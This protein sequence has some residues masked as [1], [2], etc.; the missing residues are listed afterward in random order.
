LPCFSLIF[1]LKFLPVYFYK[2]I[3]IFFENSVLCFNALSSSIQTFRNYSYF[4][5]CFVEIATKEM[6]KLVE[7]WKQKAYKGTF[8]IP[9]I[10]L[11]KPK[12]DI[13]TRSIDT[14][15]VK[16]LY[17]S[18]KDYGSVNEDIMVWC[19]IE[20]DLG[21]NPTDEDVESIKA[22]FEVIAGAHSMEA[23][24]LLAN[25]YPRN[26]LYTRPKI[27]LYVDIDSLQSRAAARAT[28]GLD[29]IIRG[30]YREVSKAE[31]VLQIHRLL[32]HELKD[33]QQS[34][35]PAAIRQ[36][37]KNAL[38]YYALNRNTLGTIMVLAGKHGELWEL[39]ERCLTGR[40]MP[41]SWKI[42]KTINK[43][44]QMGSL[45]P[46][47]LI[48]WMRQVCSG[49]ITLAD[50]QGKCLAEKARRKVRNWIRE[51][52]AVKCQRVGDQEIEEMEWEELCA[53]FPHS[54]QESF[55]DT[56]VG[57]AQARSGASGPPDTMKETL[58]SWIKID[59][60]SQEPVCTSIQNFHTFIFTS[61][62]IFFLNVMILLSCRFHCHKVRLILSGFA[63]DL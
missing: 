40:D 5:L 57:A 13:A 37:K 60:E 62:K 26:K 12:E 45:D 16:K 39:I 18:F 61:S 53:Y 29:N 23:L 49:A 8:H 58:A 24:K 7:E 11:C 63:L 6:T 30:L 28:G 41:P 59:L 46:E 42:P 47:L 52:I 4:V 25:D 19:R 55:V 15:H 20:D 1:A 38:A 31:I 50:F 35:K 51:I 17:D 27:H 36:I 21:E 33:L 54:T 43:F 9:I 22:D 34:E 3:F 2:N 44:N 14:D 10:K 32:Q 48:G 56:W